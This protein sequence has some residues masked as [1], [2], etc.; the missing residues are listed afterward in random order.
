MAGVRRKVLAKS[1]VRTQKPK[2][3]DLSK[4]AGGIHWHSCTDQDCRLVYLDT[5]VEPHAN[6]R[7]DICKRGYDTP[8]ME[9][10]YPKDCCWGNTELLSPKDDWYGW[11]RL[12]G[13]G[14]WFKCKTCH[15]PHGW[16]L[17]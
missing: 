9:W 12:A 4:L 8:Y 11:L 3:I 2:N 17:A 13:P 7:C 16:P 15:R 1:A 6:G 10:K 14:P 5:C